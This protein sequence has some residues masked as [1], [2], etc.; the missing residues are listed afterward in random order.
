MEYYYI[1]FKAQKICCWVDKQTEFD[2]INIKTNNY[3]TSYKQAR[4]F[5]IQTFI[6]S[7]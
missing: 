3:F 1:N 4:Q 5:L 6:N 2:L 7:N